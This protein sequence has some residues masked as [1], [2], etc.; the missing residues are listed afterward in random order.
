MA[1]E[2]EKT[3]S[4]PTRIFEGTGAT[5]RAFTCPKCQGE[6]WVDTTAPGFVMYKKYECSACRTE[7]YLKV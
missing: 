5:R 1:F 4:S 3:P 7:I 6:K 2:G